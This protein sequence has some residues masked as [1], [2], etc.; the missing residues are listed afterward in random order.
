[1]TLFINNIGSYPE[2][3]Q[4]PEQKNNPAENNLIAGL[5]RKRTQKKPDEKATT[6]QTDKII[7]LPVTNTSEVE[8]LIRQLKN[9]DAY[10]R[11]QAADRLGWLNDNQAV[12]PLIEALN[13]ED[14]IVRRSAVESLERLADKKALTPLILALKDKD[15]SV[16]KV[17]VSALKKFN[18][19]QAVPTLIQ[20]YHDE[21]RILSNIRSQIGKPGTKTWELSELISYEED[22]CEE[23]IKT[24]GKIGGQQAINFLLNMLKTGNFSGRL[25]AAHGL[26]EAGEQAISPLIQILID[27]PMHIPR[28]ASSI[29]GRIHSEKA[30]IPLIGLAE[31]KEKKEAQSSYDQEE[32]QYNSTLALRGIGQKAKAAV[33]VLIK[34][35]GDDTFENRI[36]VGASNAL[37][38]IGDEKGIEA[39]VE[40][41][42]KVIKSNDNLLLPDIIEKIPA[43]NIQELLPYFNIQRKIVISKKKLEE[44]LNIPTEKIWEDLIKK[45]Y[46]N[47]KGEIQDK[48]EQL[49][50]D[51]E[52]ISYFQ[53]PI[54]NKVFLL[55]KMLLKNRL[56][57]CLIALS[58]L[59]KIKTGTNETIPALVELVKNLRPLYEEISYPFYSER[60]ILE[61]ALI[62]I[63]K[64][65]FAD[66]KEALIT[67]LQLIYP[68]K[69]V[70]IRQITTT[71]LSRGAS[72]RDVYNYYRSIISN[73]LR[74]HI[75]KISFE[76]EDIIPELIFLLKQE[77]ELGPSNFHFYP[78]FIGYNWGG[79]GGWARG[80]VAPSDWD[81]Y[82]ERTIDASL[83]TDILSHIGSPAV[84][85][86]I[87][88]LS[89]ND[90]AL[91]CQATK[92]LGKMGS[93]AKAA[94]PK[95]NDLLKSNDPKISQ[96]AKETISL[97]EK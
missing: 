27:N 51:S 7:P 82:E 69:P 15:F 87:A 92:V 78:P 26:V 20:A 49:V 83:I 50:E 64:I 65:G 59:S 31:G 71:I 79:F 32:Q 12:L 97:I 47:E 56:N 84:P 24:I 75:D 33:P 46:I 41:K 13:D 61:Y 89:S 34:L 35:M 3:K 57:D 67:L 85:H 90:S 28:F 52:K 77:S 44:N 72:L 17:V 37:I 25:L 76:A 86:L 43:E 48:F 9:P 73:R 66:N 80:T 81:A 40:K 5:F 91:V 36:T 70:P 21:T 93:Q 29:L 30:V 58:E 45:S 6:N 23:I 16:R 4:I 39:V 8:S 62:N 42:I 38:L 54:E 19:E 55:L 1:M 88:A 96:V 94:I 18:D 68:K 11:A 53:P 60:L 74:E 2:I 14:A 10:Y 63:C 22:F 95:L